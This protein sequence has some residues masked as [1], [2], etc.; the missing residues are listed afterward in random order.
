M[1]RTPEQIV[2]ELV[3]LFGDSVVVTEEETITL[4]SNAG[5]ETTIDAPKT[6]TVGEV[7]AASGMEI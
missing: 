4:Q 1:E 3:S 2:D 7:M 5:V 6:M